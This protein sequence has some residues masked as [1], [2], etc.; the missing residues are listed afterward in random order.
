ML[1]KDPDAEDTGVP[2]QVGALAAREAVGLTAESLGSRDPALVARSGLSA[3]F[4]F[5]LPRVAR[6]RLAG[7]R[8]VFL[9]RSPRGARRCRRV[10]S[11]AP[12][13]AA[14]MWR[15]ATVADRG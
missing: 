5:D 9:A 10:D 6:W 1:G 7:M 15:A 4:V 2:R 3:V 13:A 14:R 8:L 12:D 11:E